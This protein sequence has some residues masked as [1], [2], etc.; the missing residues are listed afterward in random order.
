[1]ANEYSSMGAYGSVPLPGRRSAMGVEA[2]K[3]IS[4]GAVLAGVVVALGVQLMLSLLGIGIGFGT[5][6]PN[7]EANPM[8]GLG[9]GAVIW[10][11]ISMLIS[12]FVGGWVAG[13]LAGMPTAFESILHGI[14]TWSLFMLLT[15]YL[16]TTAIGSMISGV[17]SILGK[18][19]SLA[20]QGAAAAAPYAGEAIQQELEDRNINLSTLKAEV[21]QIL[22]ETGKPELT[23]E[24][25]ERQ[26]GMIGSDVE[27]G[28][29]RAA[30]NPQA[31]DESIEDVFNKIISRGEKVVNAADREAAVNVV[32][33]RTGKSR[34]EASQVVDNWVASYEQARAKL[35][36]T[37]SKAGDKAREVGQDVASTASKAAIYAFFGILLGAVAAGAGG[38]LGEPHNLPVTDMPAESTTDRS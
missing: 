30:T 18:T 27:Q 5:I 25:L 20:G 10:W 37:A 24:A 29:E 15:F 3:R 33:K 23:P 36:Q 11:A 2:L 6:D 38:K 8:A 31:A 17:G 32:M 9:T 12:L 26:G 19:I 35:E 22:R 34:A 14:L 7:T 1:M 4:W 28:A 16:L 13:R 21:E